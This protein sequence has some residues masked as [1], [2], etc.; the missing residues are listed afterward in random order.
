M[1]KL[2]RKIWDAVRENLVYDFWVDTDS[3]Q[4]DG[5]GYTARGDEQAETPPSSAPKSSPQ[6]KYALGLASCWDGANASRRMMNVLSPRM[7]DAK[8]REY[9]AW[10]QGRGCDTAHVILANGGDGEAAGYAAWRDADRAAMLARLNALKAAG[11]AVVPW[12]ITDDSAALLKELFGNPE[13]LVAK[14]EDFLAG[15]LC[16]VLGL[17]MDEG[18]SAANWAAVRTA[19]RRVYSG[20]LAVH[21]TSGNAFKFAALGDIVMGQL[22]PNCTT[23]QIKSQIDYIRKN[24]GKRAVGFEYARNADRK[25]AQAALDAGAEGCGNW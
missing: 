2:L 22:D 24:L 7:S 18:G 17:E 19:V 21:H 8:F 10:M 1:K 4:G 25:R 3:A 20:P 6:R 16:V 23:A 14:C 12:I 9:V 11:F 5:A 13:K 15:S